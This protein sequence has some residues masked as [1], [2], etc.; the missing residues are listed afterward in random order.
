MLLA[1]THELQKRIEVLEAELHATRQSLPQATKPHTEHETS[2]A[3]LSNSGEPRPETG[4]MAAED[5]QL[6]LGDEPGSSFFFGSAGTQFILGERETA[7]EHPLGDRWSAMT[8]LGGEGYGDAS[9]VS[10]MALL[11]QVPEPEIAAHY[12]EV[13][14]EA[15]RMILAE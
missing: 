6:T 15:S 3:P 2:S 10:V 5:V 4:V 12:A 8:G 7:A 9:T 11:R 13:Y 1:T 14:F